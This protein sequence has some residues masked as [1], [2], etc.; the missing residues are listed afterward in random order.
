VSASRDQLKAQA[1]AAVDAERE[2]LI[3]LSVRIHRNPEIGFQEEKASQWLC[4]YLEQHGFQIERAYCGLDTA[5]K[6]VAGEGVPRVAFLAEYDALPGLGH[7]CGHNIIAASSAGAAVA[8]AGLLSDVGGSVVVIGTPAEEIHGGKAIMAKRGAFDGLDAV[9]MFHPGSR[10]A[11]FTGALACASLSVEYFGRESHA[12]TRPEA[13]INALD[14]VIVAYNAI[15][16]LRQ[17]IPDTA[18]IHG[19][20]T[21]GGEAPNVIP[22]HAAASFLVR[23]A[24]EVYL[25]ELKEKV[26]S[27]FRAGAEATGARLEYRW[28]EVQYAPLRPNRP[29]AE[30]CRD[31]LMRRGR[32]T[33][34][35]APLGG[36]GSTDVGNVSLVA[37]TIHP[38]IAIA[39]RGVVIHTPD[40]ARIAAS[41]E[42]HRGLLDAAKVL[43][44]TAVDVQTDNGL[45]D[46]VREYFLGQQAAPA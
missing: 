33:A 15:N 3:D 12:A 18:R 7:A 39:P 30:A 9:M 42:G 32:E 19:I 13:G 44:M 16:S 45:R 17:Q 8:V 34:D 14:A 36:L 38:S 31:N 46:R 29:L 25:E 43:A 4:E 22:G 28:A 37:P 10:N 21:D 24:D 35:S 1:V 20:I 41:E 6:A 26:I 2:Q 11:V 23:A 27:C 40:F 5:F